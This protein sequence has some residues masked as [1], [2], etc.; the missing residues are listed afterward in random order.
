MSR[1]PNDRDALFRYRVSYTN[2]TTGM[3]RTVNYQTPEDSDDDPEGFMGR[4]AASI[5]ESE[6][7]DAEDICINRVTFQGETLFDIDV[8]DHKDD[9]ETARQ[10]AAERAK[11]A[12]HKA[13]FPKPETIDAADETTLKAIID[14]FD[15]CKKLRNSNANLSKLKAAVKK[16]LHG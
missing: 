7:C 13:T 3:H 16:A 11:A 1:Q 14:R 5:A 2:A 8:P 6:K 15:E 9:V 12:E 4:T 10:T